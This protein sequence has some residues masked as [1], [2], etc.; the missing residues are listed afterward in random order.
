MFAY[1]AALDRHAVPDGGDRVLE[2]V[3]TVPTSVTLRPP[4]RAIALVAC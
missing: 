2:P 3:F 4:S 1:R